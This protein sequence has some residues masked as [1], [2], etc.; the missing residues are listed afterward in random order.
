[1]N[2]AYHGASIRRGMDMR[3]STDGFCTAQLLVKRVERRVRTK[4]P[5]AKAFAK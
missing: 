1:M 2:A 4:I 3:Q 5:M